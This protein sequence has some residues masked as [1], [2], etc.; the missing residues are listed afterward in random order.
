MGSGSE[1]EMKI[2]KVDGQVYEIIKS[3]L[4]I[5]ERLEKNRF[6]CGLVGFLI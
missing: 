4:L 1:F 3:R 6:R 5:Q 2:G